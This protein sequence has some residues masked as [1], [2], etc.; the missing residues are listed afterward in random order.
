[1]PLLENS[2]NGNLTNPTLT[3]SGP[4]ISQIHALDEPSKLPPAR[5]NLVPFCITGKACNKSFCMCDLLDIDLRKVNPGRT[6]T[7]LIICTEC[8]PLIYQD[9]KVISKQ[10]E[11]MGVRHRF[12]ESY[13]A[14]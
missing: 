6:L 14:A 10:I 5:F 9:Y 7:T 3:I 1:M 11:T 12:F 4:E 2:I 8:L 13:L